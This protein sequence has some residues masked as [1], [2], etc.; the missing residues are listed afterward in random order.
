MGGG[1]MASPANL[2]RIRHLGKKSWSS[3]G[4]ITTIAI[5]DFE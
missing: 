2:T 4:K 5:D 3:K 1:S